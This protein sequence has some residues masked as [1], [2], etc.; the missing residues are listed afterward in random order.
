MHAADLQ[1]LQGLEKLIP[2]SAVGN[3]QI[4]NNLILSDFSAL[5]GLFKCLPGG[6]TLMDASTVVGILAAHPVP[7][8]PINHGCT[9][10]N[11]R[12][13]CEYIADSSQCPNGTEY[14]RTKDG[15][16]ARVYRGVPLAPIPAPAPAPMAP[17]KQAT[18]FILPGQIG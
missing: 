11:P 9:L 4:I 6:G 2:G 1:T 16:I 5:S 8:Q 3:V 15:T 13:I 10:T 17:P 12:T 7:L 18:G 14:V